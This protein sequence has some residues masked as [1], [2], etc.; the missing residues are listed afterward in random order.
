MT[1]AQQRFEEQRLIDRLL[2]GLSPRERQVLTQVITGR[3]N[4]QIAYDLG[5]TEK[6]VKVHRS[7]MMG[8]LGV[9]NVVDLVRF[10]MHAGLLPEYQLPRRALLERRPIEP[11]G[12]TAQS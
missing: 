2:A 4:K 8:K 5:I 1:S 10:A 11:A 6:T 12:A 3:L 7:H 9:R